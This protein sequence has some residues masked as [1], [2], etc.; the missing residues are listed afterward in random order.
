[1]AQLMM[2]KLKIITIYDNPKDYPGEFI[3][4]EYHFDP[5]T[6]HPIPGKIIA[7][8]KKFDTIRNKMIEMELFPLGRD[9]K[10]DPCIVESWI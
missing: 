4:R 2:D 9:I 10:D 6:Y 3:A 5:K 1:M 7:R 8:D